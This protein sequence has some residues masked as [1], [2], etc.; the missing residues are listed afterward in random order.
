MDNSDTNLV[1]DFATAHGFPDLAPYF[2]NMT[3]VELRGL[4]EA[5]LIKNAQQ[6]HRIQMIA[7][8]KFH[9]LQHLAAE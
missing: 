9:V 1:A 5:D 6:K 4:S 7:F 2:A 3:M 8:A